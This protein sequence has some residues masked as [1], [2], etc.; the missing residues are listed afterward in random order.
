M[1]SDG[2]LTPADLDVLQEVYESAASYF[3]HIDDVEKEEA[4]HVLLLHY[5]AGERDRKK[6]IDLAQRALRRAAG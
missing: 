3:S 5:R 6:L 1:A 4:V 2:V